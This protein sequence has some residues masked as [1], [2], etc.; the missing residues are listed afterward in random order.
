M[1]KK[2]LCVL[3]I[4]ISA[5]VC[6]HYYQLYSQVIEI[7]T[8]IDNYIEKEGKFPK[9]I[10][11]IFDEG[12]TIKDEMFKFDSIKFKFFY[13]YNDYANGYILVI[14]QWYMPNV[15]Y[16]FNERRIDSNSDLYSIRGL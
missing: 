11:Y 9:D 1:I 7:V 12:Y 15:I 6:F 3:C 5:R 4:V 14:D 2:I 10:S 8:K 16:F 13:G